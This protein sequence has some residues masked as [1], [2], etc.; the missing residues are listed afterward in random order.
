MLLPYFS[1]K[2]NTHQ[3]PTAW[4]LLALRKE[5]DFLKIPQ[6]TLSPNL[7]IAYCLWFVC[8]DDETLGETL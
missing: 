4:N 1:C 6:S 3:T 5:H 8:S 2:R 7:S